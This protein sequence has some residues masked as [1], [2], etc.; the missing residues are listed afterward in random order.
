MS[1]LLRRNAK[2]RDMQL[3]TTVTHICHIISQAHPK[4]VKVNP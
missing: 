4:N 3:A 1:E 2:A